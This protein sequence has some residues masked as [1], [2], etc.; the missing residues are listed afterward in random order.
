MPATV[1]KSYFK[2]RALELFRQVQRTGKPIVITDR[3]QPVL[4]L[5]PY[6]ADPEES[7]R[8]LRETVVKYDDPFE[9]VGVE[10]WESLK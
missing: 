4:Q 2:A 10:D 7:L 8:L 6:R 5:A 9:P 3:G 1:S